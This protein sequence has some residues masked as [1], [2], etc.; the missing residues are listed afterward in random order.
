[1]RKLNQKNAILALGLFFGWFASVK[2]RPDCTAGNVL[3]ARP[4]ARFK[5]GAK[6]AE[7]ADASRVANYLDSRTIAVRPRGPWGSGT[8]VMIL[9]HIRVTSDGSIET[10]GR[11]TRGARFH[12]TYPARFA[13]FGFRV[14]S[15]ETIG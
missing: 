3:V 12:R 11:D 14:F 2:G 7:K 9:E 13:R 8:G 1:M 10:I 6:I 15:I 4:V 5:V